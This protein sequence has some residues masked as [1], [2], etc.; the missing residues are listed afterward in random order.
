MAIN[1]TLNDFRNVLGKVNDGNVVMTTDKKGIEKANYGNAFLNL[2]RN[3]RTAPNDSQE[4]V[5]IRE[6]LAKAI[7]NSVEG[8][9]ISAEDMAKIKVALGVGVQL[10]VAKF[11]AP[12]SR[13][14][15]KSIIDMVDTA[16]DYGKKLVD[17]EIAV[18]KERNIFDGNVSK[19]V[20][21]AM[22]KAACFNLPSTT[23][24]GVA[25]AK[26][27]FGKDF[28]GRSPADMEKFVR[29][30]MAVIRQ[31]VFDK[32]YWSSTA[33]TANTGLMLEDEN[34]PIENDEYAVPVEEQTVTDAFKDVVASLMEKLA[35]KERI[36][37]KTETLLPDRDDV[38]IDR[39]G[40]DLW[41]KT[42]KGG[43]LESEVRKTFEPLG[44]KTDPYTTL[45]LRNASQAVTNGIR[46]M[47]NEVF[48]RS[49][50]N[51]QTT[52]EAFNKETA[53]L[54]K[55]LKE[56]QA[57]FAT[58]GGDAAEK[59]LEK[60]AKELGA[61]TQRVDFAENPGLAFSASLKAV[62]DAVKPASLRAAV[63][64][65]VNT[66]F[67]YV[68]DKAKVI[69]FF[70]DKFSGLAYE[71]KSVLGEFQR[72]VANGVADDVV[73]QKLNDCV[74]RPLADA[75]TAEVSKSDPKVIGKMRAERNVKAFDDLLKATPGYDKMS[76][77]DKA[78]HILKLKIGTLIT[79]I[80]YDGLYKLGIAKAQ[81]SEEIKTIKDNGVAKPDPKALELIEEQL[82]KMDDKELEFCS[83]YNANGMRASDDH[84]MGF[85]SPYVKIKNPF[86]T[87]L[88]DGSLSTSSV[89]AN[90]MKVFVSL[91]TAQVCKTRLMNGEDTD[92]VIYPNMRDMLHV[93]GKESGQLTIA[94]YS[95]L[96][97][98]IKATGKSLPEGC[99][100]LKQGQPYK[101]AI[102]ML[103]NASLAGFGMIRGFGTLDVGR[104]IKL[105]ADVGI[106]LTPLNGDDVNA[107]VDVYEKVLCLSTLAAM[108]G[109]KLDG[110]GD[111]AERVTGK[112]FDKVNYDD[113]LKVL[114]KNKLAST[115][116]MNL[117]ITMTD[118]LDKLEK[119]QKTM[120]QLFAG[121]MSLATAKLP[122]QD[123][124]GLLKAAREL[125]SLPPGVTK[126]VTVSVKGESIELSQLKGG[127]LRV[128][129]GG[130]PM[131]AAFDAHTLV[132]MLENEITTHP[133][134]FSPEIVKSTLPSI[135][136]VKSGA[137]PL[138]R[139]RELFAKVV[140]AKTGLLPVQFSSYTT[141]QLRSI[142]FDAVD[143]RNVKLPTEPP[144]SYNSGAMLEM[145]ANLS[146][147]SLEDLNN[148]VKLA[149][150]AGKD[151][152]AR[153]ALA[154]DPQTV[155]NVVA[156][157]FLNQDTW[158]FDAGRGNGERI[159]KF[160]VGN[161]PELS[162]IL[163]SLESDQTYLSHLPQQ[164][165]EAVKDVFRDI[166]K[167]DIESLKDSANVPAEARTA[168]AAIESKIAGVADQ[169]VSA[170]QDKVTA[171]FEPK[172]GAKVDKPDWQKTFA[173]L[174]GTEGIDV[175]TRQGAF[176]MKVLKNYFKNS[177]MV[178]KRAML[179]AFIRNTDE[180]SSDAK[181]VAELLKGAGPLLQKM[182]QGLPLTSF[183][184]ETQLALKDMKS[185]LLPIPDEAVKAQMLELVNSSNGNIL[186]IEVKKSLGAATV[187]QAFLCVIKTKD[188]PN[189]GVECVVKLLRPN[190]DTAIIREKAMID[191]LIAD[192]PAMKATFDGQYRKILEEFDLTL[193]STNVGIGMNKYEMPGGVGTVHSMQMLEGTT[194]TMT[195][196]IVKKADGLTFDAT[197]DKLRGEANA[198]FDSIKHTTEVN[199][200][201]KTVYK[202]ASF[203]EMMTARRT[204]MAKVAQLNDR[205]NHILDV[206][207]A[208]FDNALFGNGFF[209]GDLH[210]GNLMTGTNGT[211]FIDFGN[212]SRLTPEEQKSLTMMFATIV[213]GDSE[214]TVANFKSLLPADAKAAFDK[215]FPA[216]S[217]QLGDLTALLKRGTASD[218]MP[219]LQAFVAAVQG[220]DVQIPQSLQNFV[221][222]YMRL[223]DIV[224][225]IDRTVEDL[226]IQMSTIYCDLP[227][228]AEPV[229]GE[230]KFMT[231]LKPIIK[232]FVGSADAPYTPDA[233]RQA[234]NEAQKYFDSEE[235]KAE[236]KAHAQD[237]NTA[238]TLIAGFHKSMEKMF[239][240]LSNG[241][242]TPVEDTFTPNR[243]MSDLN[244][245]FTNI[246]H[247]EE[248]NELTE[249]NKAKELNKIERAILALPDA[250]NSAYRDAFRI[251]NE[252]GSPNFNGVAVARKSSMTDVCS[253]VINDHSEELQKAV[254]DDIGFGAGLVLAGK[255]KSQ[256]RLADA[257][258]ARRKKVGPE[259]TKLNDASEPGER[260]PGGD[261]AKLLRATNTF[262]APSP[263]PDEDSKWAGSPAKRADM[264][265]VISYNLSRG[266][267]ALGQQ[268]LSASAVKY[269]TLNFG[270]VDSTL[271]GSIAKLSE[272]E[273]STLLL[274]AQ[275]ID[276]QKG[277]H[278][279]ATALGA[280][281]DPKTTTLL[282]TVSQ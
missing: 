197:I 187:G 16:V 84:M 25:Y 109:F 106:D 62:V 17:K 112:T 200:V 52:Q 122:P 141:E 235:G 250:I 253:D 123:A 203:T 72:A 18:M 61:M 218:L 240:A 23:K 42:L 213:A 275:K 45:Q 252:D 226:T 266:A 144:Q 107:K 170:M 6:A 81:G 33:L 224:A 121:E 167:L 217:K 12:L 152:N 149:T 8:K 182:L 190:V 138:V 254:L 189:L 105:F 136:D 44:T 127:E 37:T 130:L 216:K 29:H 5:R 177:A 114:Q 132:R 278:E 63:E 181:Q 215:A 261:L 143:G 271:V 237:L 91:L 113:V 211:T 195:S 75:Y 221:Q 128:K 133:N 79:K 199:G 40:Q 76:E 201:R 38:R 193:E 96:T 102:D 34:I 50:F 163:K 53:S 249:E 165:R 134:D 214:K 111:F 282:T 188:H 57:D 120:K 264:L 101:D 207:K 78:D 142:A 119:E 15:L 31:Q 209:H 270:I 173:E 68:Q 239:V 67:S 146:L 155:R 206:T 80:G 169:L 41:S 242:L 13:R 9:A 116:S 225:D 97:E 232:A 92:D 174:T 39:N 231:V 66:N 210:G 11:D 227:P 198:V 178:D 238:K 150:A 89:P 164:V 196:M 10:D 14:E 47:F 135:A 274:D 7:E 257:V 83:K 26:A 129:V 272:Q 180:N 90:S 251:E 230:P 70:M 265:S 131:R 176:T 158:A 186:S 148:K 58:M 32:L 117:D 1:L 236:I 194:S 280:L 263:R 245:G 262:F 110:L 36:V 46:S 185:R 241:T 151:I 49:N 247:F 118:P 147:T 137:V 124:A 191:K 56:L 43:N 212:C 162:F 223:S 279:L 93:E 21:D 87:A 171:L 115:D 228:A 64:D 73:R 77:A 183:N 85:F 243:A 19:G 100:E 179:S 88:K 27:L 220:A 205:R 281:R 60:T 160:V 48:A 202:A 145:H 22:G 246:G 255:I 244:W 175:S 267:Q 273:Y 269:A 172:E 125:K 99:T 159:R 54:M 234:A 260:I 30:N 168:L 86:E 204:V 259:I 139:A 59:V 184:P 192:D 51:S 276:E 256:S 28:N 140:A 248:K 219:R 166:A 35:G 126:S 3:V 277:G 71:S 258:D 74:M 69:D 233:V 108:N 104:I 2:F 98:R 222:S 103:S 154:P 20:T 82:L 94:L 55:L 229:E 153:R 156:D 208:W 24:A 161:E 157:L 95:R 4:N 65:F 268:H